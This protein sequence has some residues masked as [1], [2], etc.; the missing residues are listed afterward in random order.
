MA[1]PTLGNVQTGFERGI[2]A[3]S[4]AA[5]GTSPLAVGAGALVGKGVSSGLGLVKRYRI[6]RRK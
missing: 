6:N 3:L 4:A 5:F 2:P 1:L